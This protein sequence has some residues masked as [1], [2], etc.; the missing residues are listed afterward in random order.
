VLTRRIVKRLMFLIFTWAVPAQAATST[1]TAAVDHVQS[2]EHISG[3]LSALTE[4]IGVT[5]NRIA[6]L[7]ETAL[8]GVITQTRALLVHQNEMG[9][10]FL[11]ERA[12][13][14]LDGATIF[15]RESPEGNLDA[16]RRFEVFNGA[17]VAGK[18]ELK[19]SMVFRGRGFGVFTYLEGYKFKVDSRYT[20]NVLEGR[21][22]QLNVVAFEK[23]DITT[24]ATQRLSIRYDNVQVDVPAAE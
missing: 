12:E 17:L 5:E 18:H 10:G 7:R 8:G 14:T 4:R 23:P 9:S 16:L 20:F 1:V 15:V 6:L 13:Y 19:V 21:L 22:N 2:L 3:R 11:L 24:D